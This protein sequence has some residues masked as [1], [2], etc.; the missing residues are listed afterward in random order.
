MIRFQCDYGEGAHPSILKR[1]EETNME[2]TAG[3]GEDP[4]CE[5]AR[6]KIR[7]LCE[8]PEA[9]VHF[10]VGGTQTNFT[11]ISAI[12]RPHQGVLAAQSGHINVHETGAVEATGHKVLTLP[13]TDGTI[14]AD[15]VREIWKEHWED[16]NHEHV[17]QPG[18]VYISHPT[19][20]GTL[21]SKEKLTELSKACQELG[22]PLFLDGARLGYGL[23]AETSDLTLADVAELTDVFYIGGTKVGALFGEAVVITNPALKQDFRYLI[24]QR[25]GML[26]KGRL[27]GLQFETLFTDGLY[28]ELGKRADELALRLK[29]AFLDK[30]YGLAYDSYTNQQ[31]PILPEEHLEKLREKYAFGFWEDAGEG[32]QAVRFCT[33]WATTE[34]AVESLIRDIQGL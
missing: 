12:L 7:E 29:K 18:M 4:Y 16:A 30:G 14:C 32:R 3:Y 9:D 13:S 1:L 23:M 31:F 8:S 11:V 10:L 25:G 15:Q 6:R 34:E 5:S 33:S 26:A 17:V 24:K 22:L 19:E 28:F 21:Y 20:N 2:Q 27:L